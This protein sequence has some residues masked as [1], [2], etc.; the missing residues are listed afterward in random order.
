MR[1]NIRAAAALLLFAGCASSTPRAAD[2]TLP[3]A[4]AV[5]TA[6]NVTPAPGSAV[7]DATVFS[8]DV[9]YSIENFQ[10]GTDYYIAPLFASNK[11]ERHTFN[12]LDRIS[13]APR[14]TQPEGELALRYPIRRE[15]RH[16]DLARPVRIWL[17]VMERTG[18][19]T[20]QVIGM[21]GPYEY[22]T[23]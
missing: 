8:A 15:L 7:T 6:E 18:E 1:M 19:H 17:Y 10:P 5:V 13:E 2:P 11:G 4:K 3:R 9:R 16:T 22:T 12:A 20:T 21:A 14:I 23:R